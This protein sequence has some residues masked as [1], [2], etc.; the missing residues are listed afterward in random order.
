MAGS[1]DGTVEIR[2]TGAVDSSLKASTRAAAAEMNTLGSRAR[3]SAAEIKAALGGQEV[4]AASLTAALKGEGVAAAT[5]GAAVVEAAGVGAR[6]TERLNFAASGAI[7]EYVRLGHE[8]MQGNLSRMP[9]SLVVLTSRMGNL[10]AET[11]TAVGAF[12]ALGAV[13]AIPITALAFMAYREREARKEAEALAE[14]FALSGRGALYTTA[15]V[16]AE[17][18]KLTQLE[19]VSRKAAQELVQFDAAHADLNGTLAEAANQLAP[20]YAKGI[21]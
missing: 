15:A 8:V 1:S 5:A 3:V 20:A 13:A 6:A 16:E 2:I 4:T 9:G 17:I 14:G 7:Q 12:G 21:W 10:T 19:G 18:D 11:I